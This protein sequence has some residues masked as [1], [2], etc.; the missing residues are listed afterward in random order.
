MKLDA[1]AAFD[2]PQQT[3]TAGTV[4]AGRDA[5]SSPSPVRRG[6]ELGSSPSPRAGEGATSSSTQT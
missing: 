6:A 5:G 3:G 1:P 4:A 2:G